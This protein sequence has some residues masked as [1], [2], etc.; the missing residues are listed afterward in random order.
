[1]YIKRWLL[2]VL[3]VLFASV[4]AGCSSDNT[5]KDQP[6]SS[7]E[8]KSLVI[9]SNSVSDGRGDWLKE[10]ATEKGFNIEIVEGGG[11]DIAN[12]IVAEKNNPI[13][14]V[15]FGLNTMN[16]EDFKAAGLLEKYKPV[17]ASEVSKGLN[18]KND[19]YHS[20]VKQAIL[21]IYNSK[22]YD[23]K[24]APKD[25]TDLWNKK[26][27]HGKYDAPSS[28]GG[29]TI[30]IVIAG[31]LVRHQDPKGEYGISK[32]GWD[33]IKNYL[34]YGYYAAEGEDFYANLASGKSPLGPMWSSG[35]AT[36]E[37]QYGVKAG[38]VKPEIGVPYAVEQV[39]IIKGT[40]N[41]KTA[42]EFVD[43][44]GSAEVQG[45]WAKKFSSMPANEK[46]L[47]HAPQEVKDLEA[48]LK[49]QDIDWAFVS[50]HI[51]QWVE[52]IELELLP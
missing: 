30:R 33:E 1:M 34:K 42:K 45:E 11:G 18:D 20:I 35:I 44:F 23:E 36:R 24:S 16:Y 50:K 4:L 22:L 17:W 26:E 49:T 29:G 3:G 52:K 25:W 15:V 32:E 27:F 10:K 12:R 39:A 14:D 51:N 7:S 9:Y 46:A 43:W 38:I 21:L 37:Q 19:Y 8:K 13:A 6:S 48:S 47:E 41:L 31:I 2:I 40:K 28:F 5:S